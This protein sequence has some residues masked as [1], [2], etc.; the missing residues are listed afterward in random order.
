MSAEIFRLELVPGGRTNIKYTAN[1]INRESN[2]FNIY[3][4][5]VSGYLWNEQCTTIYVL[6]TTHKIIVSED[7]M[8]VVWRQFKEL[9]QSNI[10]LGYTD[11]IVAYNGKNCNLLWLWKLTHAP[12]HQFFMTDNIKYFI[13]SY[14]V[15]GDYVSC[16]LNKKK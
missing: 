10:S 8:A 11:T 6:H 16:S 12:H 3:A 9:I 1:N 14:Q 13:D 7:L 2:T 5:P 15:I 4:N